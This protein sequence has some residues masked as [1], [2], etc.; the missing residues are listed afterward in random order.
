MIWGICITDKLCME[1][2]GIG[3]KDKICMEDMHDMWDRY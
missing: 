3:I 2:M 1:D